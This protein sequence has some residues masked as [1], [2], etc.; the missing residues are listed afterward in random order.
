VRCFGDAIDPHPTDTS[1]RASAWAFVEARSGEI[2]DEY[3]ELAWIVR[4]KLIW[5]TS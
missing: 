2:P 1:A 4:K 5:S 3:L